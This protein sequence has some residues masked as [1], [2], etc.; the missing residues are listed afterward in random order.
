MEKI[1]H[2]KKD[3]KLLMDNLI[4]GT[5]ATTFEGSNTFENHQGIY[6]Q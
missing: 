5:K 2:Q 1:E 3:K 6:N 4:V